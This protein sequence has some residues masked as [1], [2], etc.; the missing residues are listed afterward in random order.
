MKEDVNAGLKYSSAQ[1]LYYL[2]SLFE[3]LFMQQFYIFLY[4]KEN[5]FIF[6][7]LS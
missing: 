2:F 7:M 3:F 4:L 5:M 6:F 1:I